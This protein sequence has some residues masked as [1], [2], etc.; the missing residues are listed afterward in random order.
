MERTPLRGVAMTFMT[1]RTRAA[2]TTGIECASDAH[3]DVSMRQAR[4]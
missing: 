4:P 2:A 1:G 3:D